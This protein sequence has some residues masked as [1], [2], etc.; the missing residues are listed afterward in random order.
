MIFEHRPDNLRVV[1][2]KVQRLLKENEDEL[3][4]IMQPSSK[5]YIRFIPH[6]WDHVGNTHG[7]A[8]AGTSCMVVFEMGVGER[9]ASLNIIS[10]KA[11]DAWLD[12]VWKLSENP[13]FHRS[14]WKKRPRQWCTLH[15]TG[16]VRFDLAEAGI[17]ELDGIADKIYEKVRS[18]LQSANTQD[19]ITLI[20]GELPKLD[21]VCRAA[22]SD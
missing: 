7:Y 3:G 21:E 8:W 11:P 5:S 18:S 4:I 17:D 6:A 12:P 22:A 9:R 2:D 19:V 16:A 1:S 15:S 14:K 13:P 20:A 10:G